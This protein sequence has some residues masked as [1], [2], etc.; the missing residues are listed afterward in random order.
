[1]RWIIVI[2]PLM[3]LA[4]G[5]SFAWTVTANFESGADG[6]RAKGESGFTGAGTQTVFSSAASAGG[7]KSAKMTW[8]KGSEG[9]GI[10]HGSIDYPN[11][12]HGTEIWARGYY[13]FASP[14]NWTCGPVSKVLRLHIARADGSN[15]GYHSILFN[16]A[17]NI[18]LSNE[19]DSFQPDTGT[20]FDVD[21]WQAIEMYVKLS[22]TDPVFRIWKNG[23]LVYEDRSHKT[24]SATT[25]VTDFSYVMT[26]WNGGAPQEQIQYVDEIVITNER[27]GRVD[28][29]GNPMIGTIGG[30]GLAPPQGENSPSSPAAPTG[31]KLQGS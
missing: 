13:F 4:A 16:S 23:T 27:P 31:L 18:V 22:T 21:K 12:G 3:I 9:W 25:D 8:P 5:D 1:M 19:V 17:G 7:S 15:A 14:W 20:K 10:A 29:R 2:L 6:A 28:S 30:Q 26:W 24:M 11:G